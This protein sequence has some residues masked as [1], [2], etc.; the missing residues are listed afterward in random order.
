MGKFGMNHPMTKEIYNKMKPELKTPADDQK[1]MEK[2]G[3][4]QATVR[5]VRNTKDFTEYCERVFRYHGYPHRN[6]TPIKKPQQ[7]TATAQRI[8]MTNLSADPVYRAGERQARESRKENLL[9]ILLVV[10][11]VCLVAYIAI[12]PF[13][14]GAW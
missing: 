7:T 2:Y 5:N 6:G 13:L 12:L 8:T 14:V 4:G 9:A 3:F 10:L 1:A 11:L